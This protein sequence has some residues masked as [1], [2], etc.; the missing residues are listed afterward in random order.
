[1]PRVSPFYW[2]SFAVGQTSSLLPCPGCRVAKLQFL[3]SNIGTIP[4]E[5]RDA[6][7]KLSGDAE[8]VELPFFGYVFCDNCKTKIVVAGKM[9][10]SVGDHQVG[11]EEWEQGIDK[12]CFP[13]Y[14]ERAPEIFPL[15]DYVP[16]ELKEILRESFGLFW[17]DPASCANKIRSCVEVILNLLD[18]KR[19]PKK[20]RRVPLTLEARIVA[21]ENEK[22]DV[23]GKL[24]AVK[25]IGNAGSHPG[26]LSKNDLLDG[27]RILQYS[28][29]KL[30]S[31]EDEVVHGIAKEI[32]RSKKPRSTK[33]RP[34][35]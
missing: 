35:F 7:N 27:F 17:L 3:D 6:E 13:R 5:T 21:F 29:T 28:I 2:D 31:N 32:N 33:Q 12:K 1:M 9:E 16:T 18:V 4:D 34:P 20:G 30:F 24:R 26:A 19:F 10:M 25:W 8:W 23:S 14:F 15:E 22:R 11:P